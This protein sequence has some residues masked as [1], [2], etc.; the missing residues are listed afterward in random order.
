MKCLKLFISLY[1]LLFYLLSFIPNIINFLLFFFCFFVKFLKF[2]DF[3]ISVIDYDSSILVNLLFPLLKSKQ[4]MPCFLLSKFIQ[5]FFDILYFFRHFGCLIKQNSRSSN[6]L[7]SIF[8][9]LLFLR[10]HQIMIM[11][12]SRW[13]RS[14]SLHRQYFLL[15]YIISC[16]LFDNFK[17]LSCSVYYVID[18]KIIIKIFK[19]YIS[20][21]LIILKYTTHIW[22]I[23]KFLSPC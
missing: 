15:L 18:R 8:K 1:S 16:D 19:K 20:Y 6:L 17:Q 4:L 12:K 10:L 22:I 21:I 3:V 5:F 14:C 7:L 13:N 2:T 23:L 9:I 11:I